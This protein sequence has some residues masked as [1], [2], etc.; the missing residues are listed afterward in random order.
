MLV[1]CYNP[2]LLPRLF[3]VGYYVNNNVYACY[4]WWVHGSK[5]VFQITT[6]RTEALESPVCIIHISSTIRHPLLNDGQTHHLKNS[7]KKNLVL[8]D[9][10][11]IMFLLILNLLYSCYFF[12]H[13]KLKYWYIR[14]LQ[15]DPYYCLF[16]LVKVYVQ[17]AK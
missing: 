14:I 1:K 4:I 8:F 17:I 3:W 15:N 10:F 6:S 16:K 13:S 2:L 12:S 7:S 11:G 9:N 5:Q